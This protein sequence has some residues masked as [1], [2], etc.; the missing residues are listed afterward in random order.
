MEKH[1]R[2]INRILPCTQLAPSKLF[3]EDNILFDLIGHSNQYI[4][5]NVCIII[6]RQYFSTLASGME[7]YYLYEVYQT[8][9]TQTNHGRRN[10]YIKFNCKL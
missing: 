1:L 6:I 2:I 9:K 10:S 7:G 5:Y 3:I 4:I 8:I